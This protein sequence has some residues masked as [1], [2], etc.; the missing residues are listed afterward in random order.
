MHRTQLIVHSTTLSANAG[1][2]GGISSRKA[3]TGE[4][5]AF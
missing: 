2:F 5:I 1:T 3:V 4:L